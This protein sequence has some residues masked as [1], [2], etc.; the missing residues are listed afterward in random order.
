ME[1]KDSPVERIERIKTTDDIEKI[2]QVIN[3]SFQTVAEEF[4][5]TRQNAPTFP[6]FIEPE[7]IENQI[8][9]GLSL[10]CFIVDDIFVGSIGTSDLKDND[11]FKIER[12]AVL[13]GYRHQGIGKR[14]MDYAYQKITKNSGKIAQVEIVNENTKLKSWYTDNGFY[15]LRID[16]Y[17]QLPFTV[18]VLTKELEKW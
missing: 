6:A 10:Y 16:N 15:E 4:G 3:Q 9:E 7:I 5:F 12:L 14:L 11:T 1:R 18:C 13:P 8:H 2:T 17:K